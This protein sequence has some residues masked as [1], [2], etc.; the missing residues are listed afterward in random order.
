MLL[1]EFG[2][3]VA[4]VD[5]CVFELPMGTGVTGIGD[6]AGRGVGIS[7]GVGAGEGVGTSCGLGAGEGV[8][9]S[10][11]VGVGT[12]VVGG[13]TGVGVGVLCANAPTE[14][15]QSD[16]AKAAVTGK[17][18]WHVIS[19]LLGCGFRITRTATHDSCQSTSARLITNKVAR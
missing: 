10:C 7:C 19:E 1:R 12:G 2:S 17:E 13:V 4:D 15:A 9:I 18:L 8:G 11:G 5:D 3:G 14:I 16:M 6:G